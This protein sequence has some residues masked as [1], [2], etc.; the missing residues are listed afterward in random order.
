MARA[1]GCI[2]AVAV[3]AKEL[4]I[5]R[6]PDGRLEERAIPAERSTARALEPQQLRALWQGALSAEAVLGRPADLEFAFANGRLH[7]LQC[8]AL[9]SL[10]TKED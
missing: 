3:G 9:T 7:W 5:V 10:P 8:R 6:G 1:D 2:D 4:E